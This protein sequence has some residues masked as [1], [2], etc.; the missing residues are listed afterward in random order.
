MATTALL[1]LSAA[2][3]T[4]AL[5]VAA[6]PRLSMRSPSTGLVGPGRRRLSNVRA[7]PSDEDVDAVDAAAEPAAAPEP[8]AVPEPAVLQSDD[9]A[10]LAEASTYLEEV[11]ACWIPVLELL[12]VRASIELGETDG[13]LTSVPDVVAKMRTGELQVRR[14]FRQSSLTP[15]GLLPRWRQAAAAR[16]YFKRQGGLDEMISRYEAERASLLD[17]VLL[18][19]PGTPEERG[20]MQKLAKEAYD[21]LANDAATKPV[22]DLLAA[23][24]SAETRWMSGQLIDA[25][26]REL[27]L[28]RQKAARARVLEALQRNG[29]GVDWCRAQ[30]KIKEGPPLTDD[31]VLDAYMASPQANLV[32]AAGLALAALTV[33]GLLGYAVFSVVEAL[34]HPLLNAPPTLDGLLE[35]KDLFEDRSR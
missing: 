1:L 6:K 3:S 18:D 20:M 28:V 13:A 14:R 25:F 34:L 22:I 30:L 33:A 21:K 16:D 12:D 9:V 24:A 4:H 35:N 27:D 8:A 32:P 7:Q 29:R 15:Q 11:G 23:G 10:L 26:E 17:P 31:Q 19:V 5:H 2:A